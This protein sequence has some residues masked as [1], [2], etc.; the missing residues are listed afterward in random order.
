MVRKIRI[1]IINESFYSD[2]WINTNLIATIRNESLKAQI[3]CGLA[4]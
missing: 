4:P 3:W 1:C 2:G